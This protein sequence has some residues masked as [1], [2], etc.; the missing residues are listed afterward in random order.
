MAT[1]AAR[2]KIAPRPSAVARWEAVLNTFSK[3]RG[4]ASTNVGRNACRSA[5][6]FLMSALCPS[7]DRDLTAPIWMIRANTCASGRKSSVEASS[8]SKSSCSS[9]TATPSSTMKLP[10]VSMQPLGRPVVPE[11]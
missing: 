2:S 6:R 7:R 11:V 1:S 8:G 5:T 9:S 10:C 4:T 3:T